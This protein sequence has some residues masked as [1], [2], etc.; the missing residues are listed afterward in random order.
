MKV[1]IEKFRAED[2]AVLLI[3]HQ[4]GTMSWVKSIPFEDMK[5]NTLLLAH[6]AKVLQMPTVL[7]SSM[8]EHAQGPL[9]SEL[10][11]IFP[12]EFAAR[13]KRQGVI[14]AMEDINFANAVKAT[15]KKKFVVAGVTN[16]VCTVMPVL[17]LLKQGYQVQVVADAGGS[18]SKISDDMALRRMDKAGAILTSSMQALAELVGSWATP[19]GAELAKQTAMLREQRR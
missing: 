2:A 9:L 17:T 11:E 6:T 10:A 3:D 18:P 14:D 16:D 12:K 15:G 1:A 19:Q 4:V 8:E 5:L 13:V 7:T